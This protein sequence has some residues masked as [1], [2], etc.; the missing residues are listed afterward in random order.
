MQGKTRQETRKNK[1]REPTS[2]QRAKRKRTKHR[3]PTQNSYTFITIIFCLRPF[4]FSALSGVLSGVIS[5]TFLQLFLWLFW[6]SSRKM[7]ELF[8]RL[9]PNISANKRKKIPRLFLK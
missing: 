7:L 8:G 5:A 4:L 2:H 9:S 3:H 1:A 6:E